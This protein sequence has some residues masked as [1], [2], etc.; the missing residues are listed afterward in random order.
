M[1]APEAETLEDD[2]PYA[3]DGDFF[4]YYKS[5]KKPAEGPKKPKFLPNFE[6]IITKDNYE[7]SRDPSTGWKKVKRYKIGGEET[8][9]PPGVIPHFWTVSYTHLTLPTKR[10]V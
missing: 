2:V 7:I 6:I 10:I 5:D 4:D 8:E 3:D 1:P 9:R